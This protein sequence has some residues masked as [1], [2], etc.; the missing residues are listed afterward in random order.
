M[1]A[2]IQKLLVLLRWTLAVGVGLWCWRL[3]WGWWALLFSASLIWGHVLIL[4]LEFLA[5]PLV[6]RQDPVPRAGVWSH[7][8][9][10]MLEAWV[11]SRVFGWQQPFASHAVPDHWP[12]LP[13][14]RRGV[15]LVHGFFCNRGLWNDWLRRL[16]DEGVPCVALTLEPA[17]GSIEDYVEAIEEAVRALESR[18]ACAPVLVGHSMG[19]LA[20]RAWWRG[21]GLGG[22]RQARAHRVLTFGS[23]HAG[24]LMALFSL[25]RNAQQ[26]RRHSAWLKALAAQET[27]ALRERLCCYY[28]HTDNIVC[29]A[30]SAWL[31]GAE[32]T[33]LSATGH[34]SMLFEAAAMEGLLRSLNAR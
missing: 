33:H 2:R 26:M 15:L 10:W 11:C 30:S 3:G 6:N 24:T 7:L 29:P 19:G 1:N 34:V 16:T 14:G 27:D 4:G 21:H 13:S 23:P 32:G 8:R 18:T 31:E 17:F 12:D 5:L 28:S 20:I 25:A 9:A 22:D